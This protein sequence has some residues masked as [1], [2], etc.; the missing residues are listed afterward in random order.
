VNNKQQQIR[1]PRQTLRS[2]VRLLATNDYAWTL[3]RHTPAKSVPF[4]IRA[5]EASSARKHLDAITKEAIAKVASRLTVLDG[6]FAGLRYPVAISVGSR[7]FPKLLGTY[8]SELHA[9][10]EKVC[11]SSYSRVLD[12]GCAE[13]YYAVGLALRLPTTDIYAFDINP[14]ALATCRA[15]AAFNGVQDRINLFGECTSDILRDLADLPRSLIISDCEG[16]EDQL[17]VADVVPSLRSHDCIIETHDFFGEPILK[18]L[19]SRFTPT[20]DCTVVSTTTADAK[21]RG[22]AGSRL[23]MFQRDDQKLLVSEGRPGPMTW[24]FAASRNS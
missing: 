4:V 9:L 6:P 22:E 14:K 21:L 11:T 23:A 2:L 3:L 5:R 15:L 1:S 8:E 17:F 24:L 13:G 20:H 10:I 18:N 7:L 16:Y 12:I 19:L